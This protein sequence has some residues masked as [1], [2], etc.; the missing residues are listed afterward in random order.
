MVTSLAD[1]RILDFAVEEFMAERFISRGPLA[2]IEARKCHHEL[3]RLRDN[4]LSGIREE[5]LYLRFHPGF[6]FSDLDLSILRN[7]QQVQDAFS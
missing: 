1:H 5:V 2:G 3:C 6:E 4:V 7:S